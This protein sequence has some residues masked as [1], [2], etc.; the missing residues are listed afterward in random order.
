MEGWLQSYGARSATAQFIFVLLN[1]PRSYRDLLD[2]W[3]LWHE[4]AILDIAQNAEAG[5]NPPQVYARCSFCNQ[6]LSMRTAGANQYINQTRYTARSKVQVKERIMGCP[7]CNKPL[8]NCSICHLPLSCS[9]KSL[10]SPH[11]NGQWKDG[12][13]S[14]SEVCCRHTHCACRAGVM[15]SAASYF[16]HVSCVN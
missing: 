8:P 7:S 10:S 3:S 5:T 12:G 14:F 9:G 16:A 13:N 2:R 4:R 6:C 11:P 1:M 15:C